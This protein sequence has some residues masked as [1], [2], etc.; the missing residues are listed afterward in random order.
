MTVPG[1]KINSIRCSTLSDL[2]VYHVGAL[3]HPRHFSGGSQ[4]RSLAKCLRK[5]RERGGFGLL[6]FRFRALG[7]NMF[8]ANRHQSFLPTARYHPP[9]DGGHQW[10]SYATINTTTTIL[11]FCFT[12]ATLPCV[13]FALSRFR[14]LRASRRLAPM[15]SPSI[16][17]WLSLDPLCGPIASAPFLSR[18]GCSRRSKGR[19]SNTSSCCS[20][21]GQ[22][23]NI[24]T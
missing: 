20:R 10:Y 19:R 16:N 4:P 15:S 9:S 11:S 18:E 8:Q 22:R 17:G 6:L 13:I 2:R 24:R 1:Y 5:E 7:F 23:I 21:S 3:S 12:S 14:R